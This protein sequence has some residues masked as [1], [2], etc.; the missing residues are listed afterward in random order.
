MLLHVY[1]VDV[2]LC[3]QHETIRF[4]WL[5]M[6]QLQQL[7]FWP[8]K[9]RGWQRRRGAC[10]WSEWRC[11]NALLHPAQH[12]HGGASVLSPGSCG[13]PHLGG[14]ARGG[15]AHTAAG[16]AKRILVELHVR[17]PRQPTGPHR[18]RAEAT[19]IYK[20]FSDN[21]SLFVHFLVTS[22]NWV[23]FAH[24]GSI[25]HLIFSIFSHITDRDI[26][27][28]QSLWVIFLFR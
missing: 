8:H 15:Q 3:G 26:S 11:S 12:P 5:L 13:V 27:C 21:Y 18:G 22:K 6:F 14:S 28:G 24:F 25:L 10:V 20:I 2:R 23:S 4:L 16:H 1:T 19:L 7:G 9:R 17:R